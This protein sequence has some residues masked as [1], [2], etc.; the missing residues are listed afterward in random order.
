MPLGKLVMNASTK[1]LLWG[2]T[3]KKE[4]KAAIILGIKSSIELNTSVRSEKSHILFHLHENWHCRAASAMWVV[5]HCGARVG[6]L[7][8]LSLGTCLYLWQMSL[9]SNLI[10]LFCFGSCVQCF[11]P[12]PEGLFYEASLFSFVYYIFSTFI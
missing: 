8:L 2:L 3:T 10:V 6:E 5:C 4:T 7:V 12:F 1:L 9:I 11:Q